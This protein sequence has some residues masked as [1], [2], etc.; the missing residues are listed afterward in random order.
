MTLRPLISCEHGGNRVPAR[1]AALFDGHQGL[2]A[3]HRGYD[4]GSLHLA[5]AISRRLDAPLI[6]STVTRLLADLNR[7]ASNPRVFSEATRSLPGDQKRAVLRRHHQPHRDRV[8]LAIRQLIKDGD[9]VLHI[10]VHSFTPVLHGLARNADVGLLYDPARRREKALC[11]RWRDAIRSRRPDLRVR[12]NYP[13]R[14]STD[15]LTTTLRRTFTASRYLGVELEV[16]TA[17][18]SGSGDRFPGELTDVIAC[19]LQRQL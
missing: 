9:P 14:G 18:R 6:A 8:A 12:F 16:N 5:R 1:Y 3:S 15:G 17:L 7:S 13:Y 11:R 2:L 19:C 4:A 10:G